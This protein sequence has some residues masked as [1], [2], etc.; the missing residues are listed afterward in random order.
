MSPRVDGACTCI[1]NDQREKQAR[2]RA[3]SASGRHCCRTFTTG[4]VD[5][6]HD[7]KSIVVPNDACGPED[8]WK[9]ARSL[10]GGDPEAAW[11]FITTV[12]SRGTTLRQFEKIGRRP[13]GVP[14]ERA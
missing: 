9:E 7:S 1:V 10:T 5:G 6:A 12:A 14:L 8:P 11:S 3:V 2:F 4:R 13:A